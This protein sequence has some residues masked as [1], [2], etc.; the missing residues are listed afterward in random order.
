VNAAKSAIPNA[1]SVAD[2]LVSASKNLGNVT[3]SAAI[4]NG[5]NAL[6]S[7]AT[8]AST[9]S[10]AFASPSSLIKNASATEGLAK[11]ASAAASGLLSS[12]ASSLA[13]GLGKLPGGAGAVSAVTNLGA[14]ALPDIPGTGDLKGAIGE[15]ATNALNGL[16]NLTPNTS[17]LLNNLT[18]NAGGLKSLLSAGIPAGAASQLQSALSSIAGAGSGIKIPSIAL[19]TV[20]RSS[21]TAAVTSQLG[22]PAIPI[23]TFG[24]ISE[25][26]KGKVATIETDRIKF[27]E[28]L[29]E[30]SKELDKA[31]Y[32]RDVAFNEYDNLRNNLPPGDPQIAQ[33]KARYEIGIMTVESVEE[34]IKEL[35]QKY[36]NV[37]VATIP[38]ASTTSAG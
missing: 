20:D 1:G 16:G 26:T 38:T 36:P 5:A 17:N 11:S 21:I 28:E 2:S 27:A 25:E 3:G 19:N 30:L 9:A 4:A 8:S 18:S 6:S 13:S 37:A 35:N 14:S 12:T 10:T 29:D 34:K 15:L 31:E 22:D 23:P 7:I 24:E 32:L 33:W